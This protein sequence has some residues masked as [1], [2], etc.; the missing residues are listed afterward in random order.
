MKYFYNP[1]YVIKSIFS[2]FIWNTS[3][4]KILLTFDDGPNPGST[5]I[6]LNELEKNK[7]K[8]LFFC[9]GNNVEKHPE[10]VNNIIESGHSIGSHTY[11]HQR[12]TNSTKEESLIE[13]KLFNELLDEKFNYKVKYFRPPHGK[14]KLGS[15]KIISKSGMKC[16]MWSLL[17]YDYK[18]DLALVKSSVRKYIDKNS[19]IVLH[20]SFKSKNIIA[21]SINYIIE[22][23][24][25]LGL[26]IGAP[27][28][29]L[30]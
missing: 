13:M 4:N 3:N 18:N 10:L 2:N 30:K 26:Q 1:P 25:T 27:G 21:D 23:A 7:I 5:E 24:G 8:A 9:V 12:L 20:D 11:N 22:T 28:E 16:V 6:I 29:C 15:S 14:F 17:T 19:I